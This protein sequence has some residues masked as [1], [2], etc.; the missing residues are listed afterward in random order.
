MK[1]T[2][3]A[4][5]ILMALSAPALAETKGKSGTSVTPGSGRD[6][7]TPGTG[8][9]GVVVNPGSGR[10]TIVPPNPKSSTSPPKGKN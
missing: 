9:S 6:T 5:A 10:A 4:T 3:F 1:K 8:K 2:I 7:A